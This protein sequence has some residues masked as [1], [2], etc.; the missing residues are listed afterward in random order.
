MDAVATEHEQVEA[1]A[2][3]QFIHPA[4]LTATTEVNGHRIKI[5]RFC[6]L[7]PGG[8]G[9]TFKR[10]AVREEFS[11]GQTTIYTHEQG[12]VCFPGYGTFKF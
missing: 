4:R 11:E 5:S 3:Q 6:S 1:T 7:P 9:A 8:R 12:E 10:Y 2:N